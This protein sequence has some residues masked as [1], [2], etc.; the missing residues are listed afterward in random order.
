MQRFSDL[1]LIA[2][3]FAFA[4]QPVAKPVAVT[5]PS[6]AQPPAASAPPA[7][8]QR[9]APPP[10]GVVPEAP[11]PPFK[12]HRLE[13]DL[14]L[15]VIERRV[16]PLIELRLVVRSGSATDGDKPGLAA[17][18]GEL[19][20]AGGAG[21]F[22]PEQLVEKAESLGTNLEIATD[23]DATRISLNVTTGELDRAL[24][25]LAA[26]ALKPRFAPVEF[27][28]LQ[29]REL[30]RVKSAARGSAAWAASMVLYRELYN[31]PTSVHPYSRYDALPADLEKLTL[32]DCRAWHKRHFVPSN[33]SLVVVGDVS[34]D[35]ITAAAT[36]WF[37]AWKGEPAP[38][39]SFSLPFP[40]RERS[41]YVVDRPG[42]G[43]SQIYVGLIGPERK[44]PS[45]P[46]LAVANQVLGGG[47]SGRLFLDV[48]EKRSLAYSTGS[49]LVDLA[50]G[51]V[52]IVLSAGTQTAKAAE[53]VRALLENLDTIADHAP[54]EAEVERART[55]LAESFLFRLETVGSVA[56]LN[57]QL[58]V[59]GLPDDY[60]DEYRR[61]VRAAEVAK[62][63]VTAG[64]YYD[65]TPVIVV[66]GDAT[67]LGPELA[68]FGPVAVLDPQNGFSLKRSYPKKP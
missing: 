4:C 11:F 54:S 7:A 1:G 67:T 56:D 6:S 42:S 21:A 59:L 51:P 55:Y 30:E 63:A 22:G 2:A 32:A 33:T 48:R 10:A 8:A 23:R 3:V 28:K 26:V 16:H 34:A 65:G 43:Q 25:V 46:E 57:A 31:L 62:V 13:N 66:A 24:E 12:E 60:Y 19:L 47:V 58:D 45:W 38:N 20:K 40:Q 9:I 52:P 41:V 15:R 18:A 5:P 61:A 44:S 39:P 64:K 68:A 27:K 36:K 29:G 14:A 49:S 35:A 37:G 53:A 17:V 50:E